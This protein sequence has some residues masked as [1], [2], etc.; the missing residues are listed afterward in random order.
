MPTRV[1]RYYTAKSMRKASPPPRVDDDCSDT[2][3]EVT[4]TVLSLG[5]VVAKQSKKSTMKR[6]K[7]GHLTPATTSLVAS[8]CQAF[9]SDGRMMHQTHV[10]SIPLEHLDASCMSSKSRSSPQP[11]VHWPGVSHDDDD[12]ANQVLSTLRFV[13]R[14]DREDAA[15]S[16]GRF[17]PQ[18]CPIS[19]SIYRHGHLINLGKADVIIVGEEN[20]VSSM[21][22]PVSRSVKK[23][24]RRSKSSIPMMKIRGDDLKFGLKSDAMLRVLV[25]V[26]KVQT[27]EIEVVENPMSLSVDQGSDPIPEPQSVVCDNAITEAGSNG[28]EQVNAREEMQLT[29]SNE[30]R[31]RPRRRVRSATDM[32]GSL[33][34]EEPERQQEQAAVTDIQNV[35]TAETETEDIIPDPDCLELDET[36]TSLNV[37]VPSETDAD[38]DRDVDTTL[39]FCVLGAILG[40][41]APSCVKKHGRKTASSIFWDLE[42]GIE[43]D[44]PDLRD[45][46]S[47]SEDTNPFNEKEFGLNDT[48]TTASLSDCDESHG[49]SVNNE[50]EP[51]D[52]DTVPDID[53]V[54]ETCD[55]DFLAFDEPSIKKAA[56]SALAWSALALILHSPAPAAVTKLGS[57]CVPKHLD[58]T[59]LADFDDALFTIEEVEEEEVDDIPSLA[60]TAESP[61]CSP[62]RKHR[63]YM[64][65]DSLDDNAFLPELESM[66]NQ[67]VEQCPHCKLLYC[68]E[69]PCS[70]RCMME[71][72]G[73][74]SERQSITYKDALVKGE[75]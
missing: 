66:A 8:F 22:V 29:E 11:I 14:F 24:S 44:I 61:P 67:M 15:S 46:N 9:T 71:R 23:V 41:P 42:D 56:D 13:R 6:K 7:Q 32:R 60:D 20:G 30:V 62:K 59:A 55:Y 70:T 28:N 21:V 58:E 25:S 52:V 12:N 40:S 3:L 37:V 69:F 10:P 74:V 73:N 31:P 64:F 50:E 43:D 45:D 36:M 57:S 35:D 51:I 27:P 33:F 1:Q 53:I 5:G 26:S 54:D 68:Q 63:E 4:I 16:Q 47:S 38:N 39:S 34:G 72:D 19:I 48:F 18:T 75:D 17:I 2:M 65:K 49:A